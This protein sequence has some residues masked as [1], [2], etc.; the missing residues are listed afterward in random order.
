VVESGAGNTG[1][2]L[3]YRRNVVEDDRRV[4]GGEP[5]RICSIRTPPDVVKKPGDAA[6][7]G[8][9]SPQSAQQMRQMGIE[10]MLLG[11]GEVTAFIRKHTR[12]GIECVRKADIKLAA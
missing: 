2:W 4:F 8:G 10:P 11:P 12:S 1:G 6:F 5:G 3:G 9:S 7:K